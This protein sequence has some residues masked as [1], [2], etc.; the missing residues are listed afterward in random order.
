MRNPAAVII[1]HNDQLVFSLHCPC[2]NVY[3]YVQLVQ[4]V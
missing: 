3:P 4:V 1:N 2:N